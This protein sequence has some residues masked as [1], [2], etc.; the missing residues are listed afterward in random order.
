MLL[1]V[2]YGSVFGLFPTVVI[3]WFGLEHFSENYGLVSLSPMVGGNLFSLAFGHNL[4]AHSPP[5]PN[6]DSTTGEGA[7]LHSRA[8]LP[9]GAPCFAG[10][11]C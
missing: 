2:A 1:G 5:N 3:E 4:D 8:G 7:T 11:E 9:A 6:P 10:R